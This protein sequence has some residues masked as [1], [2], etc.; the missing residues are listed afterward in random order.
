MQSYILHYYVT[1]FFHP[2]RNNC[3]FCLQ[4]LGT[5]TDDSNLISDIMRG[6]KSDKVETDVICIHQLMDIVSACNEKY[7]GKG[8]G[9]TGNENTEDRSRKRCCTYAYL[10]VMSITVKKTPVFTSLLD[11]RC[12]FD[13]VT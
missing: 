9:S 2:S 5:S 3:S 13:T 8:G 7:P 4:C 1:S 6:R 10:K 11:V 12:A